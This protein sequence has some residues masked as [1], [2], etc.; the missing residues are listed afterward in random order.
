[1]DF[2]FTGCTGCTMIP[3]V[4]KKIK[5]RFKQN[6][7]VVFLSI[8]I[9]AT[10]Q[11]WETGLKTGLYTIP[12]QIHLKT[13]GAGQSDPFIM[14]YNIHGYPYL[15]VIGKNGKILSANP[16]D[17]RLDQGGEITQ[18]IMDAIAI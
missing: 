15:M 6:E 3:P 11:K 9:D 4:L 12:G 1:M 17:P 10:K 18:L 14:H 8:S 2:W 13:Q 7:D 5:D 16:K